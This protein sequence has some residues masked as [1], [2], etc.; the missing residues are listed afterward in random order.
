MSPDISCFAGWSLYFCVCSVC[1]YAAGVFM[2]MKV[3]NFLVLQINK[4]YFSC[5]SYVEVRMFSSL[6]WL[7]VLSPQ[8]T[9]IQKQKACTHLTETTCCSALCNNQ[10]QTPPLSPPHRQHHHFAVLSCSLLHQPPG[11]A[12][13]VR[14]HARHLQL[15]HSQTEL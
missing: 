12:Q 14:L 5:C 10:P 3:L 2:L 8:V 1:H 6:F 15:D 13:V 4:I 9:I 7:L 11:S